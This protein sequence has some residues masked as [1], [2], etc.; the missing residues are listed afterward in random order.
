MYSLSTPEGRRE[1]LMSEG[2]H[3]AGP[4]RFACPKC[5]A[6]PQKACRS[7]SGYREVN[8]H[9]E[10]EELWREY[11]FRAPEILAWVEAMLLPWVD[12][13]VN[14]YLVGGKRD[15]RRAKDIE[16]TQSRIEDAKFLLV[17]A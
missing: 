4:R 6:E 5:K 10:R 7:A 14:D 2:R 16:I 8:T 3:L 12:H 11:Q 9:R 15:K 17:K 13:A 1:W